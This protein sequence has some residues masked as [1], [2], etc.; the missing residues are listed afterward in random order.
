[1]F[2]LLLVIA[3]GQPSYDMGTV[4]PD[5]YDMGKSKAPV[6]KPSVPE[7]TL[8]DAIAS[9]KREQKPIAVFVGV[10]KRAV[11]G[12]IC[13]RVDALNG[14]A[15]PRIVV[16][17]PDEV[18][19][20]FT[21]AASDEDLRKAVQP[22]A[23]APFDRSSSSP[24][25]AIA[26]GSP[27]LSR[28][29]T[30]KVKSTWPE[31][32]QWP[33]NLKL[34]ALTPR[35]QSMFTMDGGRDRFAV[36]TTIHD[37]E[38]PEHHP[39]IVSGGMQGLTGW[40]SAKGLDVPDGKKIAVWKENTDVRAF[41]LVPRWRWKFPV[42][43][44]AYDVLSTDAGVFEIRTQTRAED[45]W[46]TKVTHRDADKAPAGYTGLNQS[47]A[48]C[49]NRAGEIVSVPGRIYLRE[50]WGSDGRFSWRPYLDDAQASLDYR[51]PIERK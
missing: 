51:W 5:S 13:L 7:L 29:E 36:P 23:A 46:E 15:K 27:W 10:E 3:I 43:T 38:G 41:S 34:Y 39:F 2:E 48:S 47:C 44:V 33:T 25:P 1:M 21:P 28:A 6:E 42:G 19:K 22:T 30:D 12:A 32:L 9:A 16:G 37:A 24:A 14:S 35:Y 17:N 31:S 11:P 49:H 4:K 45:G 8:I 50:R 40:R 20:L 18:G 26:D